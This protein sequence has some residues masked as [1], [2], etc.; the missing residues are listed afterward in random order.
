VRDHSLLLLAAFVACDEI[1]VEGKDGL[2]AADSQP[3]DAA[4]PFDVPGDAEASP[5]AAPD[6]LEDDLRHVALGVFEAGHPIP[7]SV[8]PGFEAALL[9]V[10]GAPDRLYRVVSVVGPGGVLV[11][12][13]GE[14]PL[15]TSANPEVATALL[16]NDDAHVLAPGDYTFQVSAEGPESGLEAEAWLVRGRRPHLQ[17]DLLLPPAT[18][19]AVDAPEIEAMARALEAKVGEAFGLEAEIHVANLTADAPA[20]LEI[21]GRLGGLATLARYAPEGGGGVDIFLH[22]QITVDGHRQGGLTGGLPVPLGLRGTAASVVAVRIALLDDFPDAVADLAVH[23]LGHA[24]G[25]YHT[26]EPHGGR[27]DLL[28][29]TPPC[30]LECDA[31]GDGVL[32]AR[33][34]GARDSGEPPCRGAA[35]NLMFWTLGGARDAS[36]SQRRVVARHPAAHH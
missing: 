1:V 29:D 15:R 12:D 13:E 24:L 6:P 27:H 26:T 17:L 32:F 18:G 8:P 33:E 31:D 22:D 34:C 21:D 28:A 35:D 7:F 5:D 10:R 25:L 9:Q 30:P 20:E 11:D 4:P 14:A 36:A 19:R 2:P 3:H 16:P 23:E